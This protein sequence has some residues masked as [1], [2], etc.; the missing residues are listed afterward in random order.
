VIYF[1]LVILTD[2][3]TSPAKYRGQWIFGIIAAV[4]GYAVFMTFGVVYFLL[5]GVLAGNVW[6]AWQRVNRRSPDAMRRKVAVFLREISPL[7]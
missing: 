5:A 6:E 3:P 1:T 4:V 7:R 2:P